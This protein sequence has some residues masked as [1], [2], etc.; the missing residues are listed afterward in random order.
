MRYAEMQKGLNAA[1]V[2]L[3]NIKGIGDFYASLILHAVYS[4]KA[5]IYNENCYRFFSDCLFLR[6]NEINNEYYRY[7][8]IIYNR[9]NKDMFSNNKEE[10]LRQKL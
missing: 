6:G 9:I 3:K 7:S 2:K 8:E 1:F 10:F 4:C 5:M